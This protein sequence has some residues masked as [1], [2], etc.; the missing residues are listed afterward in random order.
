MKLTKPDALFLYG[1]LFH[2]ASTQKMSES[3]T[4]HLEDILDDMSDFLLSAEDDESEDDVETV[5]SD[6]PYDDTSEEDEEDQEDEEDESDEEEEDLPEVQL[7][8]PPAEFAELPAIKV[9]SPSG[10]KVTLEF[11]DV[12]EENSVDVLLDEGTMIIDSVVRVRLTPTSI[13]LYDEAECHTFEVR[14]FPKSW[15]TIVS[16]TVYGFGSPDEEES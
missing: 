6:E 3:V 10:D 7:Y 14:K 12:G 16:N 13:E 4:E 8:A 2:C 5:S 1:V 11:E 15:Q 9:T